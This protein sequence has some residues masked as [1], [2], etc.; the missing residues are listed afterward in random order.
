MTV[1]RN[2]RF[3]GN[4]FAEPAPSGQ[5]RRRRRGTLVLLLVALLALAACGVFAAIQRPWVP[6]IAYVK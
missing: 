3:D 2:D 5:A 4:R 1:Q 6:L